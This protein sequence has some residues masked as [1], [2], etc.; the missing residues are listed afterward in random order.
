MRGEKAAA[1]FSSL[2][3]LHA[4]DCVDEGSDEGGGNLW[5]DCVSIAPEH[6]DATRVCQDL[7]LVGTSGAQTSHSG[8]S[9]MSQREKAGLSWPGLSVAAGEPLDG[10]PRR[11]CTVALFSCSPFAPPPLSS[12]VV[13]F[14]CRKSRAAGV[15]HV[16]SA[17]VHRSFPQPFR[18]ASRSA[19][20]SERTDFAPSFAP[21]VG[22]AANRAASVSV[23]PECRPLSVEYAAAS[24]D[25]ASC[26]TGVGHP[27]GS[28]EE[29]L[30]NVRRPDA[31]SAQIC[32]PDGV[33]L[34]FQVSANNVEPREASPARNLFAKDDWRAALADE[35][36][37]L[38]P[39]V[40]LVV[41]AEAGTGAGEGLAGARAGPDGAVVGPPGEA[42][43]V[44]P[45]AEAGECVE[46]ANAHNVS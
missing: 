44:G 16:A 27:D 8:G 41:E 2:Q 11:R 36:E 20:S 12:Y 46:L 37:P 35:A 22:H 14:A 18:I 42:K 10:V 15:G 1:G 5:D 34:S 32:R 45:G 13:A 6:T 39:E 9:P 3:V 21:G 23:V 33:A 19:P 31:R 25:A 24:L 17:A 4:F 7:F 40:A 28:K 30:S 43:G 26:L 38:G 29:P